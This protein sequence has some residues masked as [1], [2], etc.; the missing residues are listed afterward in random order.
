MNWTGSIRETQPS[1]I[2]HL[3]G[4]V[5]MTTSDERSAQRFRDQMS[6]ARSTFLE[7]VRLAK[8]PCAI[9]Y[10]SSNKVYGEIKRRGSQ[11]GSDTLHRSRF[12]GGLLQKPHRS[13]F[14]HLRLYP[15]GAA[16]QYNAGLRKGFSD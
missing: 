4:Q 5:A 10:A 16:D 2:F 7:S 9:V 12:P 3:A 11:R 6:P 13:I 15:K 8:L 14:K 1:V